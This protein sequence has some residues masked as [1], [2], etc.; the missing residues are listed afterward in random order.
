M[1]F[2]LGRSFASL[3]SLRSLGPFGVLVVAS[4]LAACSGNLGSG[5][6]GGLPIAPGG[7][8]YQQ[9]AG[10]G[11]AAV[12]SRERA[13][14]GAVFLT[15]ALASIPLPTVG[16]FALSLILGSPSPSPAA[17]GTAVP[18]ASS[19]PGTRS[20]L[21]R[22]SRIVVAQ[23]TPP[24]PVPPA[25]VT[26]APSP[27]PVGSGSP[28]AVPSPIA[29]GSPVPASSASP[30]ASPK[31]SASPHPAGTGPKIETKLVVYPD[32]AP[33]APTPEPTGNVQTYSKRKAIVRGYISPAV[34]VALYG[35]GAARFTIPAS[36]QTP[37]RG[38]TV[39]IFSASKKH[40]PQLIA[41]DTSATRDAAHPQEGHGLRHRPLRRRPPVDAGAGPVRISDAREQSV[42]DADAARLSA[43]SG[44][45]AAGATALSGSD[46]SARIRNPDAVPRALSR[47]HEPGV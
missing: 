25:V 1:R 5:V 41:S 14:E 35:L 19:S 2:W 47:T 33:D 24:S 22:T 21:Q 29:S 43:R 31:A 46:V 27:A 39:A 30:K 38:F 42:R 36:E 37:N 40:K 10:P 3:R 12:T 28:I 23:V 7:Q 6:G 45:S 32:Y 16:G 8:S 20:L 13:V 15:P 11:Q 17:S 9:P 4:G 34:D 44:L 26:G 18:A